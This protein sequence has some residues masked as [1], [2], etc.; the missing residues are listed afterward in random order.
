[1]RRTLSLTCLAITV[2]LAPAFAAPTPPAAQATRV[3][4]TALERLGYAVRDTVAGSR[5]VVLVLSDVHIPEITGSTLDALDSLRAVFPYAA[6][7][8][9]N[10]DRDFRNWRPEGGPPGPV[11]AAVDSLLARSS[12]ELVDWARDVVRR[13]Q[14]GSTAPAVGRYLAGH[15]ALAFGLERGDSSMI[16]VR[17][18][19]LYG[20]MLANRSRALRD[21]AE[22]YDPRS[23]SHDAI[24]RGLEVLGT[25]I[26]GADSSF[27]RLP[28]SFDWGN[29][30]AHEPGR[31]LFGYADYLNRYVLDDRNRGFVE[32]V[33]GE[34]A[35][36]A[37]TQAVVV[38]GYA[39]TARGAQWPS[40]PER[41]EEAGYGVIVADP[42]AVRGW[43]AR[44]PQVRQPR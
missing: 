43:L 19:F 6:V 13:R 14:P 2:V 28:P 25:F 23:P 35:R 10:Y 44:N 34:L 7:G 39:H 17:V 18:A 4:V 27:P 15:R 36:R 11:R 21:S 40:L 9:E 30:A 32:A 5:G 26:A 31:V 20:E 3:A 41:L 16:F 12:P 1:M 24:A 8:L 33:G 42:P 22:A 38:V 29:R 37:A